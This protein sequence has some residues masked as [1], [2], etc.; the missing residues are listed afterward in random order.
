MSGGKSTFVSG[1]DKS[2][3]ASI[4]PRSPADATLVSDVAI[5]QIHLTQAGSSPC[6]EHIDLGILTFSAV[7]VLSKFCLWTSLPACPCVVFSRRLPQLVL[8]A[9]TSQLYSLNWNLLITKIVPLVTPKGVSD[10]SK[11]P[12]FNR[13]MLTSLFSALSTIY[14]HSVARMRLPL[15]W[16]ISLFVL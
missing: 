5:S 7:R 14:Y 8:L 2:A 15:T 9:E 10:P 11:D 13:I 4:L 6:N 1:R 16:A 12:R 3:W